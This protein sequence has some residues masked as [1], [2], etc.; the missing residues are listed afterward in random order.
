M[1]ILAIALV[2]VITTFGVS[3]M[4]RARSGLYASSSEK[5]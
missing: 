2:A 4:L 1:I 5:C 3:N